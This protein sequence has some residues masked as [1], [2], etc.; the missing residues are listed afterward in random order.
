MTWVFNTNRSKQCLRDGWWIAHVVQEKVTCGF[1]L[2]DMV[3]V[4]VEVALL[5][6]LAQGP[7][8]ICFGVIFPHPPTQRAKV[9][10]V[11]MWLHDPSL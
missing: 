6:I 10:L 2:L 1:F 4:L 5:P 8:P 7:P 11:R 3:A 9:A